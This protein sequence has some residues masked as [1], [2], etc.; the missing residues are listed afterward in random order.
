MKYLLMLLFGCGSGGGFVGQQAED[1][2][3]AE[4]RSGLI[5]LSGGEFFLG[6]VDSDEWGAYFGEP[7]QYRSVIP[8]HTAELDD[9]YIDQFPFPG[10]EGA[11]WFTD[12]AHHSTI[13][14]L[15]AKLAD[16][17]RRACTI[18]ELLYAAAGPDNLRYPYGD[19]YTADLC[20]GDDANPQPLGTFTQ[21][22]SPLGIRDFMVRSTW[23]RIDDQARNAIDG[24]GDHE[25][26]PSDVEF[27]V[28]GGTSRE[29]T[30]QA[31]TNFGFHTH[32]KNGEDR[33]L[34]D[35]FR[36]CADEPPSSP[37]DVA[38]ER[39]IDGAVAAGSFAELFA[40]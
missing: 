26:I 30:I 32:A 24:S 3:P 7:G 4:A 39:W 34:D 23:G 21:C 6:E 27:G 10:V 33:Y 9:F 40:R 8:A 20:D 12:G 25:G 13:E 16:F 22:E 35:G 1:P 19:Q 31:P 17:G 5:G 28:Y 36:L 14:A 2:E 15:D 29:D 18:T 37:Q 11:D 38:F